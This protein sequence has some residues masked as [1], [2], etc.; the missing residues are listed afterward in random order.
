MTA[1]RSDDP[2][3]R[4]RTLLLRGDNV[5]KSARPERFGRALA[6]FEEARDVARSD[7]IDPR[8][9]ELVERRIE[10]LRTLMEA[11]AE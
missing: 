10:G 11:A 4:V 5:M 6:A 7:G 3:A 1:P 2:A 8:V 9:R